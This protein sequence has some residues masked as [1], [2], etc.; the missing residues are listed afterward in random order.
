[1]NDT[2]IMITW[3]HAAHEAAIALTATDAKAS[4]L[5]DVAAMVFD[6]A[7]VIPIEVLIRRARAEDCDYQELR[8]G[9]DA[10]L[11]ASWIE[12][13]GAGYRIKPA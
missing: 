2:D 5:L 10:R 9:L 7:K 8:I 1:M 11:N 4:A 12:R 6:S 3:V 13:S